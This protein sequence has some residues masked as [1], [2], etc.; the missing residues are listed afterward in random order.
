MIKSNQIA[1]M[2]YI[3]YLLYTCFC[4]PVFLQ[5]QQ[6]NPRPA[7]MPSTPPA[8]KTISNYTPAD[9][10]GLTMTDITQLP[11]GHPYL[12]EKKYSKV[13]KSDWPGAKTSTSIDAI[14]QIILDSPLIVLV[15]HRDENWD[16]LE[17]AFDNLSFIVSKVIDVSETDKIDALLRI[18]AAQ[19]D[20]LKKARAREF[21]GSKFPEFLDARLLACQKDR[22]NDSLLF[23]SWREENSPAIKTTVRS[24]ARRLILF[25]LKT[26]GFTLDISPFWTADEAASC[27]ALKQWLT[28]NWAEVITKSAA[29]KVNPDRK[30][31]TPSGRV[32]DL[33]Y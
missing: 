2:K 28:D 5:A 17:D 6:P 10:L 29:A 33:R 22:L 26:L 25:E 3:H 1:T 32:Y 31:Q 20:P 21:A 23:S 15:K 7:S 9:V 18:V 12:V 13:I 14:A 16:K 19:T 24:E 11:V 27:A 4:I 8:T 30:V